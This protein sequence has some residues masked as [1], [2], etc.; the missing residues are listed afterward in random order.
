MN[1]GYRDRSRTGPEARGSSLLAWLA[2]AFTH[3]SADGW[4][5]RVASGEVEVDGERV[6]TDAPLRP[7]Q[8]VIWSRAP[9]EEPAVPLHFDVLY[10]DADLLAVNKPSGLPTAPAGG[11]LDHTLLTQV[12]KRWPDAS[13]MHRLGRGTSGV[14]LFG[15]TPMARAAVQLAW[16]DGRVTKVYRARIEGEPKWAERTIEA[17]I[18]PVAHPKLGE[19]FA[20]SADGKPATSHL[21]VVGPGLLDVVIET[22][23]PHQIRIHAAYAGHPLLGDPLYGIGGVPRSDALPGDLGYLLHAWKLGIAHPGTGERLEIA[24]PLPENLVS[25]ER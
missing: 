18:G 5:E 1:E 10:E 17:P 12:R 22:G 6:T 20:A 16:R 8:T 9:W 21:M 19:V 23:R 4:A 11:F 13:P 15:L 3:T 7:G 24:A 14:V 25:A 2:G